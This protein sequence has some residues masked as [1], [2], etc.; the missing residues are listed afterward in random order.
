MKNITKF[1]LF[2]ILMFSFAFPK[3]SFDKIEK[4]AM[5][6][7]NLNVLLILALPGSGKSEVRK[8]LNTFSN[9]QLEK[10][11]GIKD[12]IQLD[13]FLYVH[14][15][16]RIS[17]ELSKKNLDPIFFVSP[18]NSFS[19]AK[20][21][22]TLMHL[23]NEDFDDL[24]NQNIINASSPTEYIF[25][26][27]DQSRIKAGLE[28]PF[29]K[30]D[31]KLKK[32]L[33]LLL[34]KDSLDVINEKNSQIKKGY[35]D[36]TIVIEFARGGADGAAF[37]LPKPYGYQYSLSLLSEKILNNSSVL[38]VWVSPEES[39]RKN[40]ARKD[41]NDPGSILNHC[42]PL[43]VMYNDYGCDDFNYLLST[44]KYPNT[45]TI[46]AHSK[47][48]YLPATRL[49]NRDDKTTFVRSDKTLWSSKDISDLETSLKD[50][51]KPLVTRK[52]VHK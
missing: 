10:H 34:D 15:M 49:D 17:E 43:A 47:R 19:N 26:R 30:M 24:I 33:C 32:E 2:F 11:F 28:A 8:F 7:N 44:S 37:P 36:K 31:K 23:L 16:R 25:K 9:D 51:F 20:E 21:W 18:V 1:M 50:A 35:K 6:E 38:Y 41:P 48:F 45:I 4:K 46:N 42:V 13:D 27:L 14:M 39:R 29:K 22:G 3:G 5:L 52:T 40:E 12:T